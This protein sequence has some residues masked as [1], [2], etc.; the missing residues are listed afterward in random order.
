[1]IYAVIV[2]D[3]CKNNIVERVYSTMSKALRYAKV[4]LDIL[5]YPLILRYSSS[6]SRMWNYNNVRVEIRPYMSNGSDYVY[7]VM[8]SNNRKKIV[9][10]VLQ[11]SMKKAT[12]Y[13]KNTPYYRAGKFTLRSSNPTMKMWK[14]GRSKIEI[15]RY[16]VL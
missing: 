15:V 6:N 2:Y 7:I 10:G 5:N 9:M 11:D 14:N 4:L 1:M 12:Y 3:E 13:V 16:E 8:M